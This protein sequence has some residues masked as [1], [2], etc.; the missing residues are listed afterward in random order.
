MSLSLHV[1]FS[2]LPAI[3]RRID[4]LGHIDRHALLDHIGAEV[5]DQTHRR[6][7]FEKTAPD[8][9]PWPAWSPA[10]A[11]MRPNNSSPLQRSGELVTSIQHVVGQGHVAIGSN[12][13]YAA[14]QNDGGKTRAHV[15]KAKN[16]KALAFGGRVVKQVNHPGSNIPARTYLG[17]SA[18]NGEDL[19]G[20]VHDFLTHELAA[21]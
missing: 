1:D 4:L 14:I 3:A 21:L 10:Y 16:K 11:A 19:L 13:V 20:I 17:I 8:G 12:K 2:K 15:I 6:I 18:E 7:A 5:V 9:T